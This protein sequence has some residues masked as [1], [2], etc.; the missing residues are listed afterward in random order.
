VRQVGVMLWVR[1]GLVAAT[2]RQLLA[3]VVA[4]TLA[5]LVG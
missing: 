1:P 4:A 5:T 2:T 3:A